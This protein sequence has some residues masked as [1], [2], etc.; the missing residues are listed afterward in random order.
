MKIV[1]ALILLILVMIVEGIAS[2]QMK[3]VDAHW[4][5]VG[6]YESNGARLGGSPTANTEQYTTGNPR[7]ARLT[8]PGSRFPLSPSGFGG[9]NGNLPTQ[10]NLVVYWSGGDCTGTPYIQVESD[11]QSG[12]PGNYWPAHPSCRTA[13]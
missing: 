9:T 1:V 10:L 3:V 4:R 8:A 2:G 7:S 13:S 12:G 11:V 5:F 6:Y